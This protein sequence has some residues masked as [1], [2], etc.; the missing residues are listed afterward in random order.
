MQQKTPILPCAISPASNRTSEPIVAGVDGVRDCR[1]TG[2]SSFNQNSPQL[3]FQVTPLSGY[4]WVVV[5]QISLPVILLDE[6]FKYLS[7]NHLD[8]ERHPDLPVASPLSLLG[9]GGL[10]PWGAQVSLWWCDW[11]VQGRTAG[12]LYPLIPTGSSF[13][14]LHLGIHR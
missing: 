8:G 1:V 4:Q 5:L 14:Q 13:G 11:S 10:N 3:I 12:G 7:R 9:S 6:A 2:G